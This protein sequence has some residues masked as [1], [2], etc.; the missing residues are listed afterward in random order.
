MPPASVNAEVPRILAWA[1]WASLGLAAAAAATVLFS[2]WAVNGLGAR[3]MG[4]ALFFAYLAALTGIG[5]L[6]A[7]PVLTLA[8]IAALFVQRRAGLRF[9]AAGAV[10]AIPIA[11]LTL[12]ER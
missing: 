10:C 3:D 9:L 11:V 12:L 7:A 4:L 5:T 8:G 6:Y 1:S 2:Q